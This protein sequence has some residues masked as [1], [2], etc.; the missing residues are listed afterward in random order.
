MNKITFYAT[1]RQQ[2]N[3]KKKCDNNGSSYKKNNATT[4][5]P[6][7]EASSQPLVRPLFLHKGYKEDHFKERERERQRER[8]KVKEKDKEV[9]EKYTSF[10]K[11][12]C[13]L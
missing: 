11:V 7:L 2:E 6:K 12:V 1:K 9:S 8:E 13:D 10:A 4:S 3:N 5:K